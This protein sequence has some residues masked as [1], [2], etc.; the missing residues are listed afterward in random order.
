M[1]LDGSLGRVMEFQPSRGK[2]GVFRGGLQPT[3]NKCRP[4]AV[5]RF[6]TPLANHILE[7]IIIIKCSRKCTCPK[8]K[9]EMRYITQQ[10][11]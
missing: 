10:T 5:I 7:F 9:T 6:D 8:M 1:N 2:H 11:E 3:V 4:T